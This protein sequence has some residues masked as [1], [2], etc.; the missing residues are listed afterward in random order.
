M[1]NFGSS[2]APIYIKLDQ[3]VMTLTLSASVSHMPC[4]GLDWK[5]Q[6]DETFVTKETVPATERMYTKRWK[7]I[8]IASS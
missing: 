1:L 7:H 8:E 4:L 6:G 3:K 2:L 5:K